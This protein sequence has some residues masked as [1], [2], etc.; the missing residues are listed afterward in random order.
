MSILIA[1]AGI[2][3]PL[4]L[5]DA[6]VLTDSVQVTF[7]YLQDKT[8]FGLGTPLR[9][10]LPFS[11]NCLSNPCPFTD[12][13]QIIV[14]DSDGN[15]NT[16][17]PYGYTT[18]IPQI[19]MD[20]YSSGTVQNTT[21][22][23]FFDIQWRRYYTASA[24]MYDNGSAYL[25]SEFRN[26][27]SLVMNG[28]VQLVEGL[29]VD[30]VNG[31]VGFRNH[32][33]PPGFQNAVTWTEDLLFIEPETVCVNS[34]LTVD[35]TIVPSANDTSSVIGSLVLTDR[36]GF[37]NL[38]DTYPAPNMTDPQS[39]LDLWT[40][41]YAAAWWTNYY[42]ALYYDITDNNNGTAG[43]TAFSH[44]NSVLNETFG[45][46]ALSIDTGAGASFLSL[47]I[48]QNFGDFT[49]VWSGNTEVLNS[50]NPATS[51]SPSNPFYISTANFTLINSIFAPPNM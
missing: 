46:P 37:A 35:Y 16:T 1:L 2:I 9:S 12:T 23:N 36:G 38:Q 43:S 11:R 27:Q 10:T 33:F 6:L 4:G 49:G 50:S 28:E 7:Q 19:T 14:E 40:R 31:G 32:T 21:I 44:M 15:V 42:S 25:V 47:K 3:T 13:V 51:G 34:N 20:I 30:M 39:N 41:A 5:Y 26:M 48:T 45:L 29:V 18:K 24:P 22:S 17:Y 8:P